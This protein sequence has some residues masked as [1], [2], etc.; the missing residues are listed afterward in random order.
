MLLVL[1]FCC[2]CHFLHPQR[3]I[4]EEERSISLHSMAS[5]SSIEHVY[6]IEMSHSKD[7][8]VFGMSLWSIIASGCHYFETDSLRPLF[9]T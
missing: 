1:V 5:L 3:C 9:Y 8:E 4:N 2:M 7:L 6:T